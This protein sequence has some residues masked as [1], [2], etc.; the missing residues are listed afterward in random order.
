MPLFE[1]PQSRVLLAV[2]LP[3]IILTQR[4]GFNMVTLI[5]QM[6]L[7]LSLAYNADCLVSGE[8]RLWAWAALIF[9]LINTIGFLFFTDKLNLPAPVSVPIPRGWKKEE[10]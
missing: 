4:E 2:A 3:V 8:C 1:S 7:Y 9:P 10:K 6:L 5:A